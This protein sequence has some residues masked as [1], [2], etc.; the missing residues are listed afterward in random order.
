MKWGNFKRRE[1]FVYF[2]LRLKLKLSH[3][4]KRMGKER[5]R[6]GEMKCVKWG[7]IFHLIFPSPFEKLE[8]NALISRKEYLI[9]I[10]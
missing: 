1:S 10:N 3:F 2:L 7:K 6:K 9:R 4:K 8:G 5:G